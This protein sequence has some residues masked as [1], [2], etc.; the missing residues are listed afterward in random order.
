M[1]LPRKMVKGLPNIS[2][3]LKL[4]LTFPAPQWPITIKRLSSWTVADTFCNVISFDVW[5]QMKPS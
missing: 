4:G 2:S 3:S 1:C 5:K